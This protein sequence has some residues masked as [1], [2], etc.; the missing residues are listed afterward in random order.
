MQMT[1]Q[2]RFGKFSIAVICT[3]QDIINFLKIHFENYLTQALPDAKIKVSS[4]PADRISFLKSINR[5]K[6]LIDNERFNFGPNL[7]QGSWDAQNKICDIRICDF[8]LTK[9]D[10][11]L[12]DRFLCRL[13]YTL[14]LERDN[15]KLKNIIIHCAGIERNGK[16]YIFFGGPGSG[17]STLASFSKKF[18]VLH[19]DMNLVSINEQDVT[20]EGVPFNPKLI[21]R[22]N[23]S[24]KLSMICSL[25][26]ADVNR[27]E[28]GSLEEFTQKILPEVFLPMLLLSEDKKYAFQYLINCVRSLGELVP[29]YRL[30]FKK[31]E[32]FWDI[33][34]K[35]EE[36]HGKH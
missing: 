9:D 5:Y 10:V 11:W 21:N 26:K 24:G 23:N 18:N 6:Y 13:F 12:F 15:K 33:I 7:I 3:N 27:I 31:D 29:Y 8:I 28:R 34:E 4:I 22:T 19:D 25:H 32:R 30:Y 1:L 35:E 16:G 17:K 14:S 36:K 20:V 2:V